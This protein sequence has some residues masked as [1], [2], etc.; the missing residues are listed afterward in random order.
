MPFFEKKTPRE[1]YIAWEIK[2]RQFL[3]FVLLQLEPGFTLKQYDFSLDYY[4][5]KDVYTAFGSSPPPIFDTRD[6]R[7]AIREAGFFDGNIEKIENEQFWMHNGPLVYFYAGTYTFTSKEYFKS[8]VSV[9]RMY[10]PF[11]VDPHFEIWRCGNNIVINT[12]LTIKGETKWE[13]FH[14]GRTISTDPGVV[15]GIF[16]LKVLMGT[17]L[18][19]EIKESLL[20]PAANFIKS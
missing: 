13:Q 9:M 2:R 16:P 20:V 1:R 7:Y 18:S 15:D 3:N 6:I 14:V 5:G 17:N 4:T 10:T 19:S 8:F 11:G 12:A